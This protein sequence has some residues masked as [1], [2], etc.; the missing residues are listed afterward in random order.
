VQQLKKE[1]ATSHQS[2]AA[3]ARKKR[4]KKR[5]KGSAYCKLVW[6]RDVRA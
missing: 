1:K 6:R 2:Y 3:K 5:E 4:E